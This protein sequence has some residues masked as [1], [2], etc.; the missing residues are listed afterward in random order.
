MPWI[1]LSEKS[2]NE[3]IQ[4]VLTNLP[5][6][7][8]IR[9]VN[10]F[11]EILISYSETSISEEDFHIL[12][13]LLKEL[14]DFLNDP[15]INKIQALQ[16]LRQLYLSAQQEILLP[17]LSHS[18]RKKAKLNIEHFGMNPIHSR[19]SMEQILFPNT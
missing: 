12:T 11:I 7:N 3:E 16:S 15:H 1:S 4:I 8:L 17:R 18:Q 5:R 6:L 10:L 9:R 14:A 2:S 13:F 19:I